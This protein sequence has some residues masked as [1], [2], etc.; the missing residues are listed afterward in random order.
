M[1]LKNFAIVLPTRETNQYNAKGDL[2]PFGDLTLLEWK[3]VQ[4]LDVFPRELIFI[5][6]AS[7]IIEEIAKEK[8]VNFLKKESDTLSSF[9]ESLEGISQEHIMIAPVTSPF[10][11][12]VSYRDIANTYFSTIDN[13]NG[14]VSV[15]SQKEYFYYQGA[16]LNF[17][18]HSSRDNLEPIYKVT[19]GVYMNKRAFFTKEKKYMSQ[20]P[21]LYQIDRF[22]AHEIRSLANY[23]VASGMI[24]EYFESLINE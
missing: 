19:N 18:E 6:G 23:E 4:L 21:F 16:Q 3:I 10:V 9:L 2:S 1:S 15:T 8:G 17:E 20:R 7:K 12:P 14:L 24:S 5:S 22:E 11:K 13:Y